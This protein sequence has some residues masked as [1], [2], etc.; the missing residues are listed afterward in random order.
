MLQKPKESLNKQWKFPGADTQ[1]VPKKA[2]L[3]LDNAPNNQSLQISDGQISSQECDIT[4]T[5]N[6]SRSI[7]HEILLHNE[8]EDIQAHIN[9]IKHQNVIFWT[10]EA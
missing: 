9:K 4:Y 3:L 7:L 1:L 5:A 10:T 8:G 6:G 2:L